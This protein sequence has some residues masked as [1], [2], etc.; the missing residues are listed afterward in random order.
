MRIVDVNCGVGPWPFRYLPRDT[1]ADLVGAMDAHGVRAALVYPLEAL[2]HKDPYEANLRLADEL[3][4]QDRLLFSP[5]IDPL[6]PRWEAELQEYLSLGARAARVFP[7]YQFD[8]EL[9]ALGTLA[10]ELQGRDVPL[11]LHGILEDPRIRHRHCRYEPT[12][13]NDIIEATAPAEELD[14]VLCGFTNGEIAACQTLMDR[15]VFVDTS[16][17]DVGGGIPR[18]VD[19]VGESQVLFGSLFPLKNY[20]SGIAELLTHNLPESVASKMAWRN[21]EGLLGEL[22]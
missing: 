19:L 12:T 8:A 5:I 10:A 15:R 16:A 1:V 4:G 22:A 21:A 6:L 11:L 14:V 17:A 9:G 13:L 3:A 2:F 18:L 7:R 20:E